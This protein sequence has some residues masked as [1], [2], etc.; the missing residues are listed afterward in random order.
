MWGAVSTSLNEN[1]YGTGGGGLFDAFD[2]TASGGGGSHG[3]PQYSW[4]GG[5]QNFFV[6]QNGSTGASMGYKGGGGDYF[7]A[8]GVSNTTSTINPQIAVQSKAYEPESYFDIVNCSLKGVGGYGAYAYVNTGW[9]PAGNGG[10]GSGGGGINS[11]TASTRNLAG[12]GGTGGGGGGAT[13]QAGGAYLFAGAGGFGGG[14]GGAYEGG[15][16]S[17]LALGGKGGIGGGGGGGASHTT[18]STTQ[19]TGGSGG[20]GVVMVFWKG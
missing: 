5:N 3:Y 16:A 13:G 7:G 11:G 6:G 17:G 10:P 20:N 1:P 9:T 4:G 14:G 18:T 12:T 15:G 2:G 19:C 8:V